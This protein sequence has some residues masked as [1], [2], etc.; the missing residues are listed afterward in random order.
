MPL[1]RLVHIAV[2]GAVALGLPAGSAAAA[3]DGSGYG[4]WDKTGTV[5]VPLAGFPAAKFTTTSTSTSVAT[6]AFLGS[7]T[8]FGEAYG[9]SQGQ[10]YL[11]ARA[12][13]GGAPSVTTIT[14]AAP[15]PVGWGFAL[16]DV[17]ADKVRVAATDADGA[18]LPTAALGWQS[19]FNY[20]Q[21][22]PK[23]GGCAGPGPFTDVP[24]WDQ[25]TAT[26]TGNV[27]DTGGASGWFR[28]TVPVRS[29]TLTFSVQAGIPVY[30]IWLAA[31]PVTISGTV[32]TDCGAPAPATTVH[33]LD[34]TG[35]PVRDATVTDGSYSF[36]GIA[37]GRYQVA[38]DAA[39]GDTA[40]PAAGRAVSATADT[41]GVALTLACPA[42][43]PPWTTA[44][45]VVREAPGTTVST[46][47]GTPVVIKLPDGLTATDA[48]KPVHGAVAVDRDGSLTYIPD[49][50]FMGQDTIHYAAVDPTG[51]TY[52]GTVT[53]IIELASTGVD[54]LPIAFSGGALVLA[55]ALVLMSRRRCTAGERPPS[56]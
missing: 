14:F 48:G 22:T 15:T 56:R 30:Q 49:S 31:L 20:C 9:S 11:F 3:P 5:T 25:R 32:G 50:G 16:G 51:A 34:A 17:D 28:P 21:N 41:S 6:S 12:A 47:P 38:A 18:A 13:A 1:S 24:R 40:G 39:G 37:A 2:L 23:P 55:G 8:P 19:A 54:V 29:L 46:P 52:T 10:Q 53:V 43:T 42:A 33:L 44:P 7:S 26:L 4:Q 35:S 45:P 36:T 27:A